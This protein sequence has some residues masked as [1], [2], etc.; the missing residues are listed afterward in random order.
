LMVLIDFYERL[1][2]AP[3]SDSSR[4]PPAIRLKEGEPMTPVDVPVRTYNSRVVELSADLEA[5]IDAVT[6]CHPYEPRQGLHFYVVSQADADGH[7]GFEVSQYL[8]AVVSLCDGRRTVGQ[9][10]EGLSEQVSVTPASA[11]KMA[12]ECLLDKARSEDLIAIYRIASA[13]EDSQ[14]GGVSAVP[15]NEP[16]AAV[17]LQDQPSVQV[18]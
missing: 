8:G 14:F 10:M 2:A 6:Q 9:V 17:S 3:E 1:A 11:H 16:S 12:Y 7:P 5:V 4:L 15:Y 18:E 13:A